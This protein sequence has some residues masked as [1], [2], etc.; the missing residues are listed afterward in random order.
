MLSLSFLSSLALTPCI[1]LA[2]S[3]TNASQASI[4]TS[5]A[6]QFTVPS[7]ADDG[8]TLLPNIKDEDAP[9]AQHH[10]PGYTA[11]SVKTSS[12]GLTAQL[13]LAGPACNVYGTDINNLELTVEYQTNSR[14][15][16]NIHPTNI[17]PQNE[18]W[19]ILPTEYVPAGTQADGQMTT[20]DLTFSWGH[21]QDSGFGFNVTRN[22]TGDVLF[23][24]TGNK[25]VYENQFIEIVTHQDKGYNLYGLGEVIHGLR[26]G[27]NLTRTIYAADV[28]DPIDENLYGSH[29]FY[30]QTKYFEIGD[31]NRTTL[32]TDELDAIDAKGNYTEINPKGS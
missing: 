31:D 2:Q 7:E 21:S 27:N 17:T 10:C 3:P 6:P 25:L 16:V 24:T 9:N 15:H 29:P 28:G 30:L 26:L 32:V 13:A 22:S 23:S 5:F 11:S 12:T 19:Y 20:S 18:S 8:A 14:L 4:A 1:A